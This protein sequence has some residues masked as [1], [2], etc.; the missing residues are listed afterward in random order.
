MLA[1][2]L[3]DCGIVDLGVGKR[4]TVEEAVLSSRRRRRHGT[5]ILNKIEDEL[6]VIERNQTE[7]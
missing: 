1:D 2:L 4:A 5:C 7:I 6:R 3:G